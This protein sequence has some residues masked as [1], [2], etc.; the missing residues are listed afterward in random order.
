MKT[1]E[2]IQFL[3]TQEF[4]DAQAYNLITADMFDSLSE[5]QIREAQPLVRYFEYKTKAVCLAAIRQ[6]RGLPA[7]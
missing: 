3:A 7:E 1:S 6:V 2:L 5:D 4:T